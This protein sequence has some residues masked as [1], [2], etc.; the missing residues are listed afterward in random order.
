MSTLLDLPVEILNIIMEPLQLMDLTRFMMTC[1]YVHNI[2]TQNMLIK[3]A[4]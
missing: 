1:S 4:L 3:K 2:P